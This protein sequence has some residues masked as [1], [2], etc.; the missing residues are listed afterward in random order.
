[1]SAQRSDDRGRTASPETARDGA[2]L[3]SSLDSLEER[4]KL[5]V[6]RYED[7]AERY[8]VITASRD[9]LDGTLDPLALEERMQTLEAENDRLSRHAAF[10]EQKI[11]ELLSR[12]RYVVE[13]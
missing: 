8:R 4:I 1:M 9:R 12:V 7:L 2:R 13:A 10:L 11:R 3:R 6:A 5:L